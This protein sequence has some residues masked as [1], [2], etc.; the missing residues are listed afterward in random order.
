MEFIEDILNKGMEDA[1][2][3]KCLEISG[4]KFSGQH[5]GDL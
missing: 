5:K 2:L 1:Q 4:V 3:R